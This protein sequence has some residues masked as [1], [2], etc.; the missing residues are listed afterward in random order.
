MAGELVYRVQG[1][2]AQPMQVS[3]LEAAG[4]RER[5]HLQEWVLANPEILGDDVLVV[6]S[7]FDQWFSKDGRDPDRLDILGLGADGR[8]VV[9]ELKRDLTP[10]FVTMQAINYASRASRF[11]LDQLADAYLRFHRGRPSALATSEEAEAQILGHAPSLSAE[12]LRNP[13]IVIVAGDFTPKVT[14][15]AVWLS[16]RG[17]DI[18][19]TRV[20]AYVMDEGHVITVSQVWPIPEAEDFVVAPTRTATASASAAG[21]VVE[22]TQDDLSLLN[23]L[24]ASE[25]ILATMDL[26]SQRPGVFVGGDEIRAVTGREAASQRGDFGGF[27][28]TLRFKFG[29]SNPPFAVNYGHGA[30][31]QQYYSVDES[32]AAM[33]RQVRGFP[34][35]DG[36]GGD[37]AGPASIASGG[38]S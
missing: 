29:R 27:E 5:D 36:V 33:W 6:T 18:C 23:S 32:I 37:Q 25:T 28:V 7:E 11:A 14:S 34:E 24:G 26:C 3:T 1:T 4:L 21:P 12:T 22:W 10:D 2:S 15:A 17:I 13:R 19:L 38:T 8:L 16:E 20:Q 35:T 9:A 30:T 31:A